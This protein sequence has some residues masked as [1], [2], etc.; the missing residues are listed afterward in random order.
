MIENKGPSVCDRRLTA[1]KI[2]ERREDS[3]LA[4][5]SQRAAD[6]LASVTIAAA[7]IPAIQVGPYQ[8]VP[9]LA[10]DVFAAF[11]VDVAKRGVLTPI[12]VDETGANLDG[13]HRFRV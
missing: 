8:F 10:P 7:N 9:D 12:D 2:S 11:K 6:P 4:P 1:K 3:A 13:H 5:Q